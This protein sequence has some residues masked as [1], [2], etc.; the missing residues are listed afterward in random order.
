MSFDRILQ[1]MVEETSG[2]QGAIF[3]DRE[4]EAIAHYPAGAGDEMKLVGAHYGI[5]W[6]GLEALVRRHLKWP[7]REAILHLEK[8]VCLMRPLQGQYLLLLLLHPSG[9]M[10]QA[11]RRLMWAAGEIQKE[12]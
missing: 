4:G 1:R 9:V 11:R 2:A 10:G 12:I 3:V 8:G 5:V 7:M 6:L